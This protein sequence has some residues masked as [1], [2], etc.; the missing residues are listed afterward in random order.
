MSSVCALHVCSRTSVLTRSLD[1]WIFSRS[2]CRLARISWP[3]CSEEQGEEKHSYV[4]MATLCIGCTG[5]PFDSSLN[6]H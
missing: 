4:S 6:I 2:V 3:N 5:L 1:L